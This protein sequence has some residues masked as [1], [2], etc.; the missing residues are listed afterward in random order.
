[1]QEFEINVI[2]KECAKSEN[3]RHLSKTITFI[4]RIYTLEISAIEKMKY[5]KRNESAY[6]N[7]NELLHNRYY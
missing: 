6:F 3:Q 7:A 5:F 2:T 4:L 1:M